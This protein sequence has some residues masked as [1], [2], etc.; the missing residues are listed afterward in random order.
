MK[1]V[2]D[3]IAMKQAGQK[4]TMMT[5]YDYTLATII[6]KT[7]IDCVLVGDSAVMVMHGANNTLQATT[8]QIAMH[9]QAVAKG[10]RSKFIIA[11]MPFMSY[12]KS[13]SETMN[14]VEALILAGA[15]AIKLEGA[16][17]NLET[18]KHIVGSGVPVMGHIG[19]TCQHIHALGGFKVQGRTQPAYDALIEQARQLERQGCFAIV[20][21]CIPVQLAK[22]ISHKIAIPTIGIGAGP[23]TDGQV[24]VGQDVLGLQT[25]F[26]PK[27]VKTYVNGAELFING[28]NQFVTE[29]QT[30]CFP[31]M[32]EA[33]GDNVA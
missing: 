10:I 20:L 28:I 1:T 3:F 4:I 18:I 30:Q 19:L 26:K 32:A 23:D 15:E 22:D 9:T 24:L 6:E 7:N 25:D 31:S 27:F 2:H 8:E 21:E 13:M 5:C 11:D 33:Y 14:A 17:G 29:V 16:T 12:R